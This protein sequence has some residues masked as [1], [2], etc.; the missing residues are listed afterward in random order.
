M[1]DPS[2]GGDLSALRYCEAE[3]LKAASTALETV[4]DNQNPNP[5]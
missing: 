3:R 2:G 1:A 5:K 4:E